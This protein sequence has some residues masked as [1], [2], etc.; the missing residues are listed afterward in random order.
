MHKSERFSSAS[1]FFFGEAL[2]CS[3]LYR[4]SVLF[5]RRRSWSFLYNVCV[6]EREKERRGERKEKR[7]R[8]AFMVRVI[9][10]NNAEARA[11]LNGVALQMKLLY[12]VL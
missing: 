4:V 10:K 12:D 5:L 2:F 6:W 9:A 11:G 8:L 7:R 1:I 3:L